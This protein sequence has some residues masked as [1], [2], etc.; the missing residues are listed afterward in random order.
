M[1]EELPQASFVSFYSFKGGVGRSM[2][3]INTAGILAGRRGF[4]VLVIDLDL[5]APG[6]S[7]LNPGMPDVS[8]AQTQRELPFKAGFVELLSDAK[9]RGQEA[10]L[11]AL[12]AA[13]IA[14]RYTQEIRLPE[15]LREFK[16]GSLHIM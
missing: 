12:T 5:E 4:R 1:S 15:D 6:L 9:E 10:D 13:D 16:D 11:F 8:P 14:E 3:L 2:A 7:Y